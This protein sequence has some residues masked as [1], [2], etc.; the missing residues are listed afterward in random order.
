MLKVHTSRSTSVAVLC[1]Q[2][3]VIRGETEK[4]RAAVVSQ[5]DASVI[6]LDLARVN[7]I[8]AGGL[9]VL[10]ELRGYAESRGVE[11]RLRNVTKL[12]RRILEITKLDSVFEVTC[13]VETF[14]PIKLSQFGSQMQV[15][16]CA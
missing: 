8:D 7:T 11:F 16:S 2:G 4:L 3:R 6:V 1:V 10:L 5:L 9:G 14:A 15:A 12:V 13:E